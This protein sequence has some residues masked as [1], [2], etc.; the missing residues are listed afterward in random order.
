MDQSLH[1]F[2]SSVFLKGSTTYIIVQIIL[3]P[4]YITERTA[5]EDLN[6]DYKIIW[7]HSGDS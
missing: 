3:K 6:A 4:G 5:Y 1:T 2:I 7:P